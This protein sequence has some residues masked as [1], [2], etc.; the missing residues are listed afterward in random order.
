VSQHILKGH[1]KPI[2]CFLLI[3]RNT[4]I[5]G[6]VDR[7]I[8]VINDSHYIDSRSTLPLITFTHS[9]TLRNR[10]K[11]QWNLINFDIKIWDL[12]R[13]V[14]T[15]SIDNAH[16]GRIQ[17]IISSLLYPPRFSIL[18]PRSSILTH[19][20]FVLCYI[21][22]IDSV[23]RVSILT[24]FVRAQTIVI[25][26]SGKTTERLSVQLN[27]KKKRVH[28]FPFDL[29]H[30]LI[31]LWTHIHIHSYLHQKVLSLCFD[32]LYYDWMW[33]FTLSNYNLWQQTRNRIC[34][35]STLYIHHTNIHMRERGR[36][37]E[38]ENEIDNNNVCIIL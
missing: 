25:Y 6:S 26:T 11:W 31:H 33:R 9:K 32:F 23:W 30:I 38:R 14:C 10:E 34:F 2:T 21:V 19:S 36:E 13:G 3:D 5:S 12:D 16:Q 4:L 37:R 28:S 20:F 1:T 29:F 27:V 35:C 22:G 15:K 18:D 24:V 17:V 7:S 8:K